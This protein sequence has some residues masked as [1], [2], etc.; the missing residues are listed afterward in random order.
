MADRTKPPDAAQ[1]SVQK[2]F[3]ATEQHEK[4]G[5]QE[6]EKARTTSA[7]KIAKLRALCL[8]KNMRPL[9]QPQFSETGAA[10]A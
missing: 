1:K 8:A 2:Y 4:L 10:V 5:R 7:A 3:T 6:I 9:Y